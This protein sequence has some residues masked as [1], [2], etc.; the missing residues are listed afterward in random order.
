MTIPRK[1]AYFQLFTL[2]VC[3]GLSFLFFFVAGNTVQ[4]QAQDRVHA[5]VSQ[6][7]SSMGRRADE[8][9]R[10][11]DGVAGF[12]AAS[13]E[14]T[15]QDGDLLLGGVVRLRGLRS[16]MVDSSCRLTLH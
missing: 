14:V 16:F 6:G 11:L 7:L 12:V 3:I 15:A 13:D 4:V 5:L 2:C 9:G 10:T 1:L 8:Y